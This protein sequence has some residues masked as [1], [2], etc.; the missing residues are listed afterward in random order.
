M[1]LPGR[2][3]WILRRPLVAVGLLLALVTGPG[4]AAPARPAPKPASPPTLRPVDVAVRAKTFE[5]QGN[6]ASALQELK[7]LRAMQG[8]DADVELA[9]ALDEA[10][11]GLA[12]SAWARLHGPLLTAALAD[13]AGLVRRNDY[14]FQREQ[15]WVNGSF[16]GWYW[17]IA[18]A[19]AELTGFEGKGQTYPPDWFPDLPL[20]RDGDVAELNPQQSLLTQRYS[21]E[22]TRF[23]SANRAKPFFLY[24]AYNM[25]HVP[26]FPGKA[27]E[28]KSPRGRYGDVIEELDASVGA[29]L[30]H[31]QK[32]GLDN[33]TVSA[34][35]ADIGASH[36]TVALT[37]LTGR[38][39][40][41]HSEPLDV[42]LGERGGGLVHHQDARIL[43]QRAADPVAG[44]LVGGQAVLRRFLGRGQ[45]QQPAGQR[46]RLRPG[47]PHD[48]LR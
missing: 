41:E 12:D 45:P 19:R 33:D 30:E 34:I 18:R 6:Y 10:R 31:V 8:P 47:A 40:A 14:P 46:G 23:I 17:Y 25:P 39:I 37:D 29:I 35:A 20:M 38:L 27:Y 11:T 1:T 44:E 43:G 21:V 48:P 24:L 5:E 7:R 13:T 22:A 16:D 2:S 15:L 42:A 4:H 32:A 28:G 26:L 9:I 3:L 36:A